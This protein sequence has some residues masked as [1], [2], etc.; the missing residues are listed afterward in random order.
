MCF[1][2]SNDRA[3][4]FGTQR[5]I[6]EVYLSLSSLAVSHGDSVGLIFAVRRSALVDR[7]VDVFEQSR[8]QREY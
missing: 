5:Q 2:L 8:E 3:R 4:R 1:A 7:M 6:L